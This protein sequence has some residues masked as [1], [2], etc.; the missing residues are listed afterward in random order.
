MIL[1]TVL[2]VQGLLAIFLVGVKRQKLR[3]WGFVFGL[4]NEPLWM[5][6]SWTHGLY[7]VLGLS[8]VSAV[9]WIIGLKRNWSLVPDELGA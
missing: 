2:F 1:Q 4:A 9:V 5:Y 6:S 3:R 8:V 7:G